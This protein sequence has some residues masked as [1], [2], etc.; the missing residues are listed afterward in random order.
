[1]R[2]RYV[3]AGTITNIG[4]VVAQLISRHWITSDIDSRVQQVRGLGVVG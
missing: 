2:E 4:T 1:M 3:F